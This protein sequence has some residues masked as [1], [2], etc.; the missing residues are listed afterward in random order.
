MLHCS[1]LEDLPSDSTSPSVLVPTMGALHEGHAALIRR[2]REI[3]GREGS[4]LVSIFLNPLQFDSPADLATYPRTIKEDL[5]LCHSLDVDRV[6]TP[7]PSEFYA[8]DH[9]ISVVENSLSQIL[10]GAS[11]PGHFEGVCTV[12]LKLGCM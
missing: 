5:S 3:A 2:A 7:V 10:C 4:V 8:S 12:V 6:Y 9:S 11:R 1:S